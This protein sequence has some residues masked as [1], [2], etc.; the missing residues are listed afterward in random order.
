MLESDTPVSWRVYAQVEAEV[1]LSLHERVVHCL[2]A[3]LREKYA[4]FDSYILS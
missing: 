1:D 2:C 4:L 3:K